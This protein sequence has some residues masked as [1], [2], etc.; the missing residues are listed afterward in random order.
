MGTP[1]SLQLITGQVVEAWIQGLEGICQGSKVILISPPNLAFGENTDPPYLTIRFD[2]N[3]LQVSE[4][5]IPELSLFDHIDE[6]KDGAVSMKEFKANFANRKE[7]PPLG[8]FVKN[9]V[10]RNDRLTWNEFTGPKGTQPPAAAQSVMD[11]EAIDPVL[12][13][14]KPGDPVKIEVNGDKTIEQIKEILNQKKNGQDEIKIKVDGM[15]AEKFLDKVADQAPE[16]GIGAVV[17]A[18]TGDSDEL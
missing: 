17:G 12:L 4:I 11:E 3:L 14:R 2:I 5:E 6:N 1:I 15:D 18:A 10:N 13:A 8:L 7:T 9:D 16:R